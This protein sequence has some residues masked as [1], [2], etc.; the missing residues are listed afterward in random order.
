[1]KC[2][3]GYSPAVEVKMENLK[4]LYQSIHKFYLLVNNALN[5]DYR[6][7]KCT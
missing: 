2:V 1:M 5:N 3:S 6:L 4:L 7:S